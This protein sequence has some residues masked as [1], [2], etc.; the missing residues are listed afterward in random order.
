MPIRILI[1]AIL[2]TTIGY[3]D[4]PPM[5]TYVDKKTGFKISY[6][7]GWEKH[8]NQGG[9]SLK[10]W[11]G[12]K[13]VIVEVFREKTAAGYPVAKFLEKLGKKKRW[14]V[15]QSLGGDEGCSGLSEIFPFEACWRHHYFA[16][17]AEQRL[18]TVFRRKTSMFVLVQKFANQA[19]LDNS[20]DISFELLK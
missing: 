14:G 7:A 6:P 17:D 8:T 15:N 1:T 9:V 2:L 20:P 16:G 12:D 19:A 18:V 5:T 13:S 3:A 11:S 4:S 10:L